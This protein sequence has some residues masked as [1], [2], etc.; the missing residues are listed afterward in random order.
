MWLVWLIRLAVWQEEGKVTSLDE[1]R[2]I[3][4]ILFGLLIGIEM[5]SASVRT[6]GQG[7]RRED[8]D[9]WRETVW[10]R[11][12]LPKRLNPDVLCHSSL[13]PM[14]L[15]VQGCNLIESLLDFTRAILFDLTHLFILYYYPLK[16]SIYFNW[17]IITL[18]YCDDF[19]PYSNVNWP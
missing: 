17:R 6:V 13:P 1:L 2:V 9:C 11:C 7:P 3:K 16:K 14:Q 19:L 10:V 5:P 12:F 8:S 4:S 15:S 18:R